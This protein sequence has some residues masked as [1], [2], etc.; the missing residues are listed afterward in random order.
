MPS[1]FDEIDAANQAAVAEIFGEG[2]TVR[3]MAGDVNYG[4]AEDADRPVRLS[5]ASVQTAPRTIGLDVNATGRR[6]SDMS[7]GATELWIGRAEY[8][9]LGYEIRRGDVIELI[10]RN[11]AR[12]TVASVKA[13]D[14]GDITIEAVAAGA[15]Q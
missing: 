10:E 13:G 7:L 1:P 14:H 3:P 5:S 12:L 8:A 2:V 9:A 11:G 6:G 4:A 15:E